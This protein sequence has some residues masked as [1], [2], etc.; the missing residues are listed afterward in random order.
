MNYTSP[1]KPNVGYAGSLSPHSSYSSPLSTA[2]NPSNRTF[3]R[4]SFTLEEQIDQAI[5]KAQLMSTTDSSI[6]IPTPPSS[7]RGID[8]NNDN[9]RRTPHTSLSTSETSDDRPEEWSTDRV[10][11]WLQ[12]VGLGMVADNF[13]EQE[14]T[15]DVLLDLTIDSLKELGISTYGKRYKVITAINK[16]K[17]S[18]VYGGHQSTNS[19]HIDTQTTLLPPNPRMSLSTGHVPSPVTHAADRSIDRPFRY[20]S[21]QFGQPTSPIDSDSLYQF[22][23]KAPLPPLAGSAADSHDSSNHRNPQADF[24]RPASSQSYGSNVSRS[25][26]FNTASTKK[27]S[28]SSVTS[29]SNEKNVETKGSFFSP[30]L[31]PSQRIQSSE[32]LEKDIIQ[33]V[34]SVSSPIGMSGSQS[35]PTS[36]ATPSGA[37]GNFQEKLLHNAVDRSEV[38]SVDTFKAP[39]HE[40]WL[41]KRSDRYKTWNKRWFVLKGAN[42][43][44][45]KSPKDVR[46]KGIV[47]LRGYRI[48]V[49]ESIHPGKYSFKAQHER[50]RTFFFYTDTEESLR[51]WLQILIKATIVRDF[52]SP[53]M[54]SNHVATVPLEVARR[55][56]PRPPSMIMYKS[57]KPPKSDPKMAK[58]EEEEEA[59]MLDQIRK[60]PLA[61]KQTRESGVTVYPTAFS[62][63]DNTVPELPTRYLHNKGDLGLPTDTAALIMAEDEDLIDPQRN[64]LQ[65]SSYR[66][67]SSTRSLELGRRSWSKSQY[68]EWINQHLSDGKRVVDLASAFRNSDTLIILLEAL[69]NKTVRRPPAQK[70]GSVSMLMLDNMV[71]AFKFMGRNG[72]VVDGRF[73][74]KDIF[75][76]NEEKVMDMLDAIRTWAK[77]MKEQEQSSAEPVS[78]E[79]GSDWRNSTSSDRSLSA[80]AKAEQELKD[81][82]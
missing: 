67:S 59:L 8:H 76:G 75:G 74:I 49:D 36:I 70:G 5:T 12:S 22:P 41:H 15:G 7:Q 56:K 37:K 11:I 18:T 26:T 4:S 46:M 82:M 48:V 52:A 60:E 63:E 6:N 29:R 43:F 27:S 30:R 3:D 40:G 32:P 33:P 47:N 68:I 50:E 9:A 39:E 66:S 71:A 25:N 51:V 28:A 57:Q 65:A 54:S 69:S 53:V 2:S 17:A 77:D 73:T 13:V 38:S 78:F 1:V 55:M 62:D 23:R 44:Y 10:A 31:K 64:S 20:T 72:V 45:F 14:I 21:S 16:L 35:W 79:E 34:S 58:L 61:Y 81:A 19:S 80:A 42:L 24:I